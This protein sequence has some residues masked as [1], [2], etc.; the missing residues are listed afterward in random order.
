MEATKSEE[1]YKEIESWRYF[2]RQEQDKTFMNKE[3]IAMFNRIQE[4]TATTEQ[5]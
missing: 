1:R 5:E 3:N 2:V 4:Y